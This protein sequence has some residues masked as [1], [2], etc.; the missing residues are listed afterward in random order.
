MVTRTW[1]AYLQTSRPLTLMVR[2]VVS[3]NMSTTTHI[4][5]VT[6]IHKHNTSKAMFSRICLFDTL[7]QHSYGSMYILFN[8]L[9]LFCFLF[10]PYHQ[11]SLISFSHLAPSLSYYFPLE[12][13]SFAV[14]TLK[15]TPRT[16]TSLHHLLR[17]AD[18]SKQL[19]LEICNVSH[20]DPPV[21]FIPQISARGPKAY[22]RHTKPTSAMCRMLRRTLLVVLYRLLRITRPSSAGAVGCSRQ[23]PSKSS[24]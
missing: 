19:P 5:V 15:K 21:P 7:R 18:K 13:L 8:I 10:M 14:N 3:S 12:V 17:R 23:R 6:S 9:H 4:K 16:I 2:E 11:Y 20:A 24:C 1:T 22:T